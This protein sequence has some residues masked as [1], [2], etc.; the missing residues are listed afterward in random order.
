LYAQMEEVVEARFQV[1]D[2]LSAFKRRVDRRR[3]FTVTK[4]PFQT[5][6]TRVVVAAHA[7]PARQPAFD[8]DANDLWA[9]RKQASRASVCRD[10][11]C[12]D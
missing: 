8:T 6:A 4:G 10:G 11:R 12:I 5:P 2:S 3:R 9:L 7:L 1:R